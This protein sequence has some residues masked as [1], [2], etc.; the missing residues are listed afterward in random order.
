MV[1]KEVRDENVKKYNHAARKEVRD[2]SFY[3]RKNF[4]I[5]GVQIRSPHL[6]T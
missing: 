2:E 1:Q 5:P 4:M 3:A 6:T